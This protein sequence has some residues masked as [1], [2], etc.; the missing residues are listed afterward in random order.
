MS[1]NSVPS[2]HMERI[3]H[4][5]PHGAVSFEITDDTGH[6]IILSPEHEHEL[7]NWLYDQRNELH[8]QATQGNDPERDADEHEAL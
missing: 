1:A 2:F 7:L 4:L 3:E 8:Q 6:T 5:I